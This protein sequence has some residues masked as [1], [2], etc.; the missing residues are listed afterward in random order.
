MDN[1]TV[2]M[3]RDYVQVIEL[4]KVLPQYKYNLIP[5]EEIDFFE[6]HKDKT[7]EFKLNNSMGLAKQNISR[8]AY[9]CFVNLYYSYI[10]T[11]EEKKQIELALKQ[12]SIK[13]KNIQEYLLNQNKNIEQI[14]NTSEKTESVELIKK[15][16]SFV[17]KVINKIK[18][19]FGFK[20]MQ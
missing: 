13:K 8:R 20:E 18:E 10:A 12:N 4:L 16:E 2:E 6:R 5:K 14:D 19:F 11:V 15:E 7:Y 17:K 1:L 9:A 3:S